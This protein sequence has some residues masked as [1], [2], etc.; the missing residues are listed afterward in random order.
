MFGLKPIVF[1]AT[2]LFLHGYATELIYNIF[3][4]YFSRPAS[5]LLALHFACHPVHVEAV[6][7]CV[8]RADILATIFAIKCFQHKSSRYFYLLAILSLLAKEIGVTILG[9]YRESFYDLD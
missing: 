3:K 5:L 7:N 4:L 6:A 9:V 2:N 1:H 8:G